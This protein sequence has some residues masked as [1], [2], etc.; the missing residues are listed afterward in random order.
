MGTV[1]IV[2]LGLIGGSMGL[3]VKKAGISGTEIVGFDRDQE[4]TARAQRFG[5]IDRAARSAAEV[6]AK[7]SIIVIATPIISVEKVLREIANSVQ[8]GAVVTDTASTKGSVMKW[9]REI[10]PPGVHFVGG[11]PMAGKEQSGPQAADATLFQDRPYVVV[12]AVDAGAGAVNAVVGLAETIGAKPFFLDAD[13]HDAYAAAI[14]HVPL[15][16]SVALFALA[17]GST[18]WPELA[19]M[20]GPG[21]KDLTRLASGEPEMAH[22]I[23]LTNKSNI[24][25]W[26]DRYVAELR[27]LQDL[28]DG[29]DDERLFRAFAETQLEREN[30]MVAPPQRETLGLPSDMPSPNQSFMNLLAGGMWAE[31]AREITTSLE[32][33]Q[34]ERERQDR[35]RRKE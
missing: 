20:A 22:D 29:E 26:I 7:A 3:A 2:G 4:V 32:E 30:Y 34:R 8:R 9:A 6:A 21:F 25:H 15:L 18:A 23:C 14:S 28:I 31:R 13:E 12:P 10:L 16:A 17:R 27:R 1:G 35:L 24:S 11:H 33:R 19:G 5:A